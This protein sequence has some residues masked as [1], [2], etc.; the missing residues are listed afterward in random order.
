MNLF[1]PNAGLRMIRSKDEKNGLLLGCGA[2]SEAL[3][4]L[5]RALDTDTR[6]L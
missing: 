6:H 1:S 3:E 5:G 2:A 4:P